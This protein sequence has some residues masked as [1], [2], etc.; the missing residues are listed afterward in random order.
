MLV[1]L[2]TQACQKIASLRSHLGGYRCRSHEH[3]E[4]LLLFC[5]Y[6]AG[7]LWWRDRSNSVV[8]PERDRGDSKLECLSPGLPGSG[9][10]LFLV[11]LG[12]RQQRS[13]GLGA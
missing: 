1:I 3:F 8:S 10:L 2:I 5:Q 13:A 6:A 7:R 9:S 4:S 12:P 11:A